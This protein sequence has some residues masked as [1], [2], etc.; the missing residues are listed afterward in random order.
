MYPTDSSGSYIDKILILAAPAEYSQDH[1]YNSIGLISFAWSCEYDPEILNASAEYFKLNL[2]DAYTSRAKHSSRSGEIP[3][4]DWLHEEFD[5]QKVEPENLGITTEFR[6]FTS[7]RSMRREAN[8]VESEYLAR[9]QKKVS[10][11]ESKSKQEYNT[12]VYWTSKS[13][14]RT[15]ARKSSGV[16]SS[17]PRQGSSRKI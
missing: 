3:S 8:R 17:R 1:G 7:L 14:Q 4:N 2:Q 5:R 16:E 11:S 13:K 10:T 6:T 9:P 12:K 15:D